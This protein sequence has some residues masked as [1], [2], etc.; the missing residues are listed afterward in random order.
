MYS[1]P[2]LETGRPS[3]DKTLKDRIE[4]MERVRRDLV[5]MEEQLRAA[6]KRRISEVSASLGASPTKERPERDVITR[7]A[8]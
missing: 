2:R 7:P 3:L 8:N 5:E 4:D 1:Y 6:T